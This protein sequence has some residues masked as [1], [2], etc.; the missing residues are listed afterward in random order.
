[1]GMVRVH[2]V[3]IMAASVLL[4][5]MNAASVV[6]D[7]FS[8]LKNLTSSMEDTRINANDLAFFLASHNFDA[9]PENGYVEVKLDGRTLK[10]IPNG[11]G[12]G[13]CDIII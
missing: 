11:K 3:A 1:M 5:L 12:P 13:L 6:A 10:L 4:I 9:V 7:D 8:D 2:L